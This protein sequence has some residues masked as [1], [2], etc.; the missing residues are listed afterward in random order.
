MSVPLQL[1]AHVN[2]AN[3]PELVLTANRSSGAARNS[4]VAVSERVTAWGQKSP[5]NRNHLA[6]RGLRD[7]QSRWF[8]R[9]SWLTDGQLG[10]TPPVGGVR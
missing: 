4:T 3:L 10:G 1:G 7:D 5:P 8:S 9:L 2:W 6:G